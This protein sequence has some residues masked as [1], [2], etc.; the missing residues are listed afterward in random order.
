VTHLPLIDLKNLS[1][2]PGI[3][4][5]LDD[6]GE[7]LYVGKAKNLKKRVSSYFLN[8]QERD[9]KT[10]VLV[11][12]IR[13]IQTIITRTESEAFILERQL[14]QT[15]QPRYNIQLKDD[16]NYPYIKITKEPFPKIVIVRQKYNDKAAY[17]G[18][19]P[20]IGS[21]RYLLRLLYDLFP[22]RDCKQDITLTE[23]QPKCLKLDLKKC[24]GPCV[25]KTIK[26]DYDDVVSQLSD[27]LQ[28]RQKELLSQLKKEMADLAEAH[29]FEKAATVR[30]RLVKL[31]QL[32]EKQVVQLRPEDTL[33]VW[34][35]ADNEYYFYALV[36]TYIEGKLLYQNGFYLE[37]NVDSESDFVDQ[38]VLHFFDPQ[39]PAFIWP[40]KM[41]CDPRFCEALNR[42]KSLYP[43]KRPIDTIAPQKGDYKAVLDTAKRNAS[44]ALS[45]LNAQSIKKPHAQAVVKHLQHALSLTT[46]PSIIWGI[47]ISHFQASHIVGSVVYFKDGIPYK[48]G[49]R[50]FLI[51]TVSG[52]SH[53]PLSIFE[54]VF[55][56]LRPIVDAI[57]QAPDLILID[58][59]KGQLRFAVEAAAK[60]GVHHI[61]FISLAK[62]EEL[63][64]FPNQQNPLQLSHQDL[65][66]QLLQQVRDEAHRFALTFQRSQRQK[67]FQSTLSKISG[68]GKSRVNTLYKQFGTLQTM[69]NTELDVLAKVGKM[70]KILAQKV[71]EEARKASLIIMVC[72]LLFAST[73]HAQETDRSEDLSTLQ[74]KI[75]QNK[76]KIKQKKAEKKVAEQELGQLSQQLRFTAIK[77]QKTR[78]NLTETKQKAE[79]TQTKLVQ[80][81]QQY[82]YKSERFSNR[83]VDIYK[84]KNMGAIEFLFSPS[85]LLSVV[86]VSYYFD[87]I[88]NNDID[89]IQDIKHDFHSL[90]S[91][92]KKLETQK[93]TLSLLNQ[94]IQMRES[95]LS[96][97]KQQQQ[98][99]VQSLHSEIAEME[100]MN[101]DLERASQEITSR[102]VRLG[103][104]TA[105]LGS[106]RFARPVEGW[107]SSLF[108]YRLHP[109]FKRRIFHNGLDFAAPQGR[110]IYAA[111]TGTVIV[112]GE[113][114][115]Y[116]G[117]GKI[118]IIDHGRKNGK[119]LATVYAHQSQILVREGE[120]VQKGQEIGRVGRT[121]HATGPHLHFEV[122]VDG[123][124]TNPLEYL[125]L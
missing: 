90:E 68:L 86:D 34:A 43:D 93:K 70:G 2:D 101:R 61:P 30:D 117:Y 10:R 36:Q 80:T 1:S 121:G 17:F 122:R 45:R 22:L 20:S 73:I 75:E 19:Y 7:V 25:I 85:S 56:R 110:P 44:L 35:L 114:P 88:M 76:T 58:G 32:F 104:G 23:N 72:L 6:Q 9:T 24:L 74:K 87:R 105:Y 91:E 59:G 103:K 79:T 42:L 71:I 57:E 102:I 125:R 15:L 118:T 40:K 97:K 78:S 123:I 12:K 92:T 94:E 16:K 66:L 99:Y 62:K 14:I 18:P 100:R 106:G 4:K 33:T 60:Q 81:K 108:G 98:Q 47:D 48:K 38:A 83:I 119:Q 51:K 65:G 115:Q 64:Y 50:H 5:M 120:T 77:L 63:V 95:L 111:E 116:Y 69:A 49:Y 107:L 28:G 96:Q 113:H 31:Q 3:Y 26:P 37:K 46:L 82:G 39:N 13:S 89:M 54:V 84:N 21:T 52:T 53:D 109:I 124:P 55:R 41:I 112:A 67:D 8:L 11:T 27:F 29:R